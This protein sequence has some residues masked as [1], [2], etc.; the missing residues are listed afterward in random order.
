MVCQ[1]TANSTVFAAASDYPIR[2]LQNSALLICEG[3]QIP[4][5]KGRWC[6][7]MN[8]TVRLMNAWCL[9]QHSWSFCALQWRHN[10]RDGVSNLQP[11]GCLLNRLFRRRSKKTS[12]L[13]VTGLCAG[14][15]PGTGEFPA[16][17]A[18]YAENASIRWRHHGLAWYLLGCSNYINFNEL[19]TDKARPGSL[20]FAYSFFHCFYWF[21]YASLRWI[22]WTE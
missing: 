19:P 1:I 15:S 5:T 3:W 14:N 18:S 4:P 7:M 8:T 12:K 13:R 11:H 16:Q 6:I 21:N 2:I 22:R 9:Q 10:G 20:W 17:M